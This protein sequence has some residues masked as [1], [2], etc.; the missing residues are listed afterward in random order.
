MGLLF[1]FSLLLNNLNSLVGG[2]CFLFGIGNSFRRLLRLFSVPNLFSFRPVLDLRP[3]GY[4]LL[5]QKKDG[6]LEVVLKVIFKNIIFSWQR[7]VQP[8]FHFRLLLFVSVCL[9]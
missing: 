2:M 4:C 7:K 8:Q 9:C 6:E 5:T 1:F 3:L